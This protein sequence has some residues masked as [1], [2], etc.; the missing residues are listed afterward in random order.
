[1]HEITE[2]I[3]A[4][5]WPFTTLVRSLT[6]K[7]MLDQIADVLSLPRSTDARTQK[8]DIIVEVNRRVE[9]KQGMDTLSAN[10]KPLTGIDF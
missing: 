8:N 5:A 2:F 1:M 4:I 6:S 3:R 7:S 10:A 9:T